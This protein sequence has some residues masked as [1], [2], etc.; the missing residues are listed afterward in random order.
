M[1]WINAHIHVF[2][3]AGSTHVAQ[4]FVNNYQRAPLFNQKIRDYCLGGT[5]N[6]QK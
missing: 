2:Q 3:R 4:I 6:R 5:G 1:F